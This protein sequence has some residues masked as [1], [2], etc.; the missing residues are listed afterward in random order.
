MH[1][2]L[3]PLLSV[4]PRLRLVWDLPVDVKGSHAEISLSKSYLGPINP[5]L[6][7]LVHHTTRQYSF[8]YTRGIKEATWVLHTRS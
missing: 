4:V 5:G 2:A 1:D 8:I 7:R 6:T 3:M